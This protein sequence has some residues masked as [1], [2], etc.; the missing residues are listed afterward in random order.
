MEDSCALAEALVCWSEI[1]DQSVFAIY[2]A[3]A[4]GKPGKPFMIGLTGQSGVQWDRRLAHVW[5]LKS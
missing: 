1:C 3:N 5:M 2:C 4:K